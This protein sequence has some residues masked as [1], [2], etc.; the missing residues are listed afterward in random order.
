LHKQRRERWPSGQHDDERPV[1]A[2][3]RERGLVLHRT[4]GFRLARLRS[5]LILFA[6]NDTLFGH[7]M[8]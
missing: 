3:Q 4:D 7:E 2:G 5:P 6:R 8:I 1:P